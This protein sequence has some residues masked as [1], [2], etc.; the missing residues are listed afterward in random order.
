M[1]DQTPRRI[2]QIEPGYFRLRLVRNGPWIAAEIS[3]ENGMIVIRQDGEIEG[4]PLHPDALADLITEATIEGEAFRHPIIRCAWFGQRITEAEFLH[5]LRTSR[6]AKANNPDH[7]AANP[8]KP[9]DLN[10]V[11]ITDIF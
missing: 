1:S 4:E 3:I 9:I 5:L 6:W 7:P 2:D 10:R 11:P 8:T